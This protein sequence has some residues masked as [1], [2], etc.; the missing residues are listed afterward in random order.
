MKTKY[1]ILLAI[2]SL[3]S[4]SSDNSDNYQNIPIDYQVPSNFPP[5][6]YNMANNPLTEK[7]FELGKKI[8]YLEKTTRLIDLKL[9]KKF[10]LP[11]CN[12][13]ELRRFLDNV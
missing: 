2:G 9:L 6:A 13:Y 4:C 1:L 5:L 11:I 7:G 8:F 12:L 3:I 10:T